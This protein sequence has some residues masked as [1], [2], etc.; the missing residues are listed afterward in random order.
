M[1]YTKI[2]LHNNASELNRIH[3]KNG[4]TLKCSGLTNIKDI[5]NK[6][7]N[8]VKQGKYATIEFIHTNTDKEWLNKTYSGYYNDY[9][10]LLQ[11]INNM[12]QKHNLSNDIRISLKYK[13]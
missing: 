12:K 7:F 4:V 10:Q 1:K 2:E 3:F 9:K 5:R 13:G 6:L 8:Q 11:F